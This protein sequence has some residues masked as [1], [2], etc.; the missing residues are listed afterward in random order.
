M[1]TCHTLGLGPG[2]PARQGFLEGGHH[3][4]VAPGLGQLLLDFLVAGCIRQVQPARKHSLSDRHSNID[5][6]DSMRTIRAEKYSQ[7]HEFR[8]RLLV[9]SHVCKM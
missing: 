8:S 2:L 7:A 6:E 1:R 3:L 9:V 5:A 4:R